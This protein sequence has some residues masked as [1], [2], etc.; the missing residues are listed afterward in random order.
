M[1]FFASQELAR[2][3]TRRL[4]VLYL[5]SIIGLIGAVYL[6]IVLVGF[7][8]V[9][10]GKSEFT[11]ERFAT[12]FRVDV[13]GYVAAA[14]SS[15]IGAGSAFKVASLRGGGE[16]VASLLGG[17]R[18]QPNSRLLQER[19][20]L[21]VVEEMALAAGTPVPP[22]YLLDGEE[23]I[24]AFAAGYTIDDAVIG[25]NRGTIETLNRDELQGVVAHEF[26]HILNGDMRMSIRMIGILHGIQLIALIGYYML[27]SMGGRRSTSSSD[28]GK[29]AAGLLALAVGLIAVGGIGILFARLIK[30]SVSRQREFLA[31]ASAVQFTR[32]PDGIAGALKM[33]GSQTSRM[34]NPA[35]EETSHMF[36]SS[37]FGDGGNMM[38]THP[39]LLKRIREIDPRFDGDYSAY[40]RRRDEAR[41]RQE[42][43]DRKR[44]E[45][46]E[47][48]QREFMGI[49]GNR[50][51]GF[52]NNQFPIDP[53]LVIAGIG[54]PDEDDVE[55]SELVVDRIPDVLVTAS[56]D[57]FDSR[58]IVFA[59]LLNPGTEVRRAQLHALAKNEGQATIDRTIELMRPVDSLEARFRLPVFEILQGTLT[60]MSPE[61][62]D[63]FRKSIDF[64]V[65][66]D[67]KVDL[68]EFFLRHHLMVHLD[69][70]YGRV[71]PPRV[72]YRALNPLQT[73]VCRLMAIL[74]R[75]GHDQVS[76]VEKAWNA[77]L[78][79]L[80]KADWAGERKFLSEPLN[81]KL[82]EEAIQRVNLASPIIKKR[83]LTAMAEAIACDGKITVEEA[84]TFRAVS[85]SLDCPV[86]PVM[87]C[88]SQG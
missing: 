10:A 72:Q 60:G 22:V 62:Y 39:P 38:A 52:L 57:V 48:H 81:A 68:F 13:L 6:L 78:S 29:G 8:F 21:N 46:E 9:F 67:Q 43:A 61:Q 49:G 25:L 84:E 44:R 82:L 7:G 4:I 45:R 53:L 86:P 34:Q 65:A 12:W 42:E 59:T 83:V 11:P 70:C 47:Q 79:S 75:V 18:L 33:I 40:A 28:S 69:R 54:N 31:D 87:A 64:L 74:V 17:R 37:M 80:E 66:A 24:N 55:Y 50:M 5:L 30:A 2:K 3:N 1:D 88:S 51:G 36:F 20:I 63:S 15:V 19:R 56:R 58:C 32:N 14:V 26:S 16:S 23:G 27:R 85:E 41:R 73:E 71:K 77:G 76:E 35:A